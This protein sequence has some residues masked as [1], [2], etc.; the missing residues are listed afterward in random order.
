MVFFFVSNAPIAEIDRFTPGLERLLLVTRRNPADRRL[1]G[2]FKVRREI[3]TRLEMLDHPIR[4]LG[5]VGGKI[6]FGSR[7]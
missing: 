1:F 2:G 7:F 4:E 6:Q 3:I 5:I